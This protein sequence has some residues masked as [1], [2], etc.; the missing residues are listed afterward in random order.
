[1]LPRSLDVD[2]LDVRCMLVFCFYGHNH[3]NTVGV[4]V[5]KYNNRQW[6]PRGASG[7]ARM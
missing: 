7:L 2:D 4:C 1:M 3:I 6:S 5:N